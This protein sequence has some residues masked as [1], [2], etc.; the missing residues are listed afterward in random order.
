[1]RR[2]ALEPPFLCHLFLILL[3]VMLLHVM[4]LYISSVPL[5][6]SP[7]LPLLNGGDAAAAAAAF[8]I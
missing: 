2:F 7:P 8:A 5:P 3:H 6:L 1:M 4:L